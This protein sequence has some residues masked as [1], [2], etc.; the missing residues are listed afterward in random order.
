MKK[1]KFKGINPGLINL[2]RM[3]KVLARIKKGM[4]QQSLIRRRR[5]IRKTFNVIIV[6]KWDIMYLNADQREY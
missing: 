1:G 6:K 2:V 4:M 5:K 3:V